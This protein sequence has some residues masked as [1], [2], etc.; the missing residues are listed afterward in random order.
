MIGAKHVHTTSYRPQ[1]NGMIERWHRSLKAALMCHEVESWT[2]LL[3]TVLLGLRT[4]F[5]EDLQTSTA[6]MLC[7]S[8]IRLP[9]EFVE[10]DQQCTSPQIFIEEFRKH[11]RLVR[12]TPATHHRN[13]VSFVLKNLYNCS[14]VLLRTDSVRRP[15]EPPY[16]GPFRVLSRPTDR[17]FVIEIQGKETTVSAERLKPAFITKEVGVK[18][19]TKNPHTHVK[20]NQV[21]FSQ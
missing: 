9:N 20:R 5:K 6:E 18:E 16:T 8:P 14:H 1:A 15:L 17:T 13:N 2:E 7:G 10:D 11:M 19:A 21:R 3:P 12:P 4:R